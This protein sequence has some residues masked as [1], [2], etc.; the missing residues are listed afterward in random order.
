MTSTGRLVR[1]DDRLTW[2]IQTLELGYVADS[3]LIY[4]GTMFGVVDIVGSLVY[5][6]FMMM[7]IPQEITPS[8]FV[9]V[10]LPQW[11]L[12]LPFFTRVLHGKIPEKWMRSLR[13]LFFYVNNI[14]VRLF[15]S[16]YAVGVSNFFCLCTSAEQSV[17]LLLKR[18]VR[19]DRPCI[20][21]WDK[22][23]HPLSQVYRPVPFVSKTFRDMKIESDESFP[24]GDA[25]ESTMFAVSVIALRGLDSPAGMLALLLAALSCFGRVYFHAHNV[26]DVV[27]GS[28][29]A[30]VMT[31]SLLQYT[32]DSTGQYMGAT[33]FV[34]VA[35]CL[36]VLLPMFALADIVRRK[37]HSS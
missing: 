14:L 33:S 7:T 22:G 24:S 11:L 17:V 26:L 12:F 1:L 20:A 31:L 34:E 21:K 3:I 16:P 32:K 10:I 18:F 30:V 5:T 4:P 29:I 2:P 27:G 23:D 15:L 25:C 9:C 8:Y 13:G 6:L 35:A 19:R 36:A 37:T 28:L